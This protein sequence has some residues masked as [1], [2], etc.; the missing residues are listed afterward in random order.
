MSFIDDLF[1]PK[2]GGNETGNL[3]RKFV[4][5]NVS[6]LLGNGRGIINQQQYD[7]KNLSDSDYSAKYAETKTGLKVAGVIPNSD[8]MDIKQKQEQLSAKQ[9]A[10]ANAKTIIEV[11]KA[12]KEYVAIGLGLATL[13]IF[14]TVQYFSKNKR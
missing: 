11:A 13:F 10:K 7:L 12:Y 2:V 3:I 9:A 6:P 1:A 8:I 4:H 14:F 5:E